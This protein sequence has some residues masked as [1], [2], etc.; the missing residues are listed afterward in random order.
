[1]ECIRI[2]M[3]D[4]HVA[5]RQ[6]GRQRAQA[7]PIRAAFQMPRIG[8]RGKGST[9]SGCCCCFCCCIRHFNSHSK[10]G[11]RSHLVRKDAC[12]PHSRSQHPTNINFYYSYSYKKE[13][14]GETCVCL[15]LFHAHSFHAFNK[16][17]HNGTRVSQTISN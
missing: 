6:A 10:K 16:Q 4:E 13:D 9:N 15:F 17:T 5:R 1:V 3:Q 12:A 8:K 14:Y 7:A 2:K 11:A